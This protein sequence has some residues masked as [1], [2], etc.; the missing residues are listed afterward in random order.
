[1]KPSSYMK[2]IINCRQKYKKWKK[3][4]NKIKKTILKY[5]DK[6]TDFK[7]K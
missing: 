5:L 3:R 2:T 4:L 1:M 7:N 6:E